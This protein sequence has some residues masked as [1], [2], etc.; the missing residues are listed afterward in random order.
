MMFFGSR[1]DW[2][3]KSKGGLEIRRKEGGGLVRLISW[4]RAEVLMLSKEV[5]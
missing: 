1:E 3:L 5:N 4:R 2:G